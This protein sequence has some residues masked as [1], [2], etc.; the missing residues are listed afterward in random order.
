MFFPRTVSVPGP[1][2]TSRHFSVTRPPGATGE[3]RQR[4]RAVAFR[5]CMRMAAVALLVTACGTGT[6]SLDCAFLQQQNCWKATL[7]A[8]AT[9]VPDAGEEGAFAADR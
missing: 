6:R 3:T 1:I 4:R 2:Q 8:A 7:A 9:C 5:G